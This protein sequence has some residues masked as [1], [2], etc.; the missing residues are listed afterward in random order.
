ML[1]TD[2]DREVIVDYVKDKIVGELTV[3]LNGRPARVKGRLLKFPTIHTDDG[4]LS[5]EFAWET[6]IRVIRENGGQFNT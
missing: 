6:I 4:E 5:A 1:D 2:K 3:T